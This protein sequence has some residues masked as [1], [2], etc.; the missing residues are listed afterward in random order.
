[1]V[2]HP[3]IIALYMASFLVGSMALYS[4]FYGTQIQRKWDIQERQRPAVDPGKEDL[5]HFH[6][7]H[8]CLCL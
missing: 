6:H 3:A 4:A 8:L 7:S 5:P 2:F 1:M